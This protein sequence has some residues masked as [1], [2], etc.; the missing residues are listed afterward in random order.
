MTIK[1]LKELINDYPDDMTVV[2]QHNSDEY[3]S[4][5]IREA[6]IKTLY[7]DEGEHPYVLFAGNDGMSEYKSLVLNKH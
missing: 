4:P 7:S 5:G 2:I 6:K 1:E 3:I